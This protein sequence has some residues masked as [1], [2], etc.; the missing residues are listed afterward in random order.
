MFVDGIDECEGGHRE[1]LDSLKT[2]I[3]SSTKSKLSIR[4]Y[5]ASRDELDIRLRLPVYPSLAIHNFTKANI[6]PY[7][8]RKSKAAWQ[9]RIVQ[10]RN[11]TTRFNQA[12]IDQ[13]VQ[14]A[15]K[16]FLWVNLA[17]TQLIVGIEEEVEVE[18]LCRHLSDL[19]K[20]LREFYVKI[21][22]RIPS[23]SLHDAVNFLRIF[24]HSIDPDKVEVV[25]P[26]VRT[27]WELCA[28]AQHPSIATP[29]K[30][31]FEKALHEG[32]I[33]S[34]RDQCERMK[35][36]IQRICKGLIHVEDARDLHLHMAEVKLLH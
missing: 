14:K 8:N 17:V 9:E 4:A 1:Q 18:E 12:L 2:Y 5:I 29:Y 10:R 20:G 7:V 15:E 22:A 27:V 30:A 28:T 34:P 19:P 32:N 13:V 21:I 3:E 35:R 33:G 11:T 26:Q 6:S 23:D 31:Y 36:R 24:D 25:R 16:V